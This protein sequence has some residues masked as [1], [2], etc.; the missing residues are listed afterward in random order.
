MIEITKPTLKISRDTSVKTYGKFVLEPLQRGYGQTMGNSLRRLLLSS[1]PGACISSVRIEGVLHEF[2]A[3]EGLVEDV[4]D[5][6]LNLK[7][8]VV[9]SMA[10]RPSTLKLKVTGP[11]KVTAADIEPNASVEIINPDC[12][13]CELTKE[14]PLE[15]E[16]SVEKGTG[17]KLARKNTKGEYPL[18]TIFLDCHF[19]PIT[20]VNYKI[21]DTR[22]GQELNYDRLTLEVWTN[23][24]IYP[25]EAVRLSAKMLQAHLEL[26]LNLDPA[27]PYPEEDYRMVVEARKEDNKNIDIPIKDLEFSVRSRNCLEQENIRTLGELAKKRASELLAI[28]NFGKKSLHEIREKLAVYGLALRDE[29]GSAIK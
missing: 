7:K 1:M 10:D 5:L 14:M 19:S 12:Y 23:G 9:R 4:I 15:M 8:I 21:E 22:V 29:E 2:S 24:A 13:I 18:N 11:R 27:S 28:K 6:I 25:T 17:Y 20:R 26:F 3:V 16:M